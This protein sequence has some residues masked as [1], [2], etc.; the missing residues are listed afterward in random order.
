MKVLIE[1][2]GKTIELEIGDTLYEALSRLNIPIQSLCSGR[3][4]CGRCKVKIVKGTLFLN[5]IT[6]TEFQQLTEKEVEDGF[7]LA[8]QAKISMVPGA[9]VV[10]VPERSLYEEQVLQVEGLEIQVKPAPL[11]AKYFVKLTKPTLKDP[12]SDEDRLLAKLKQQHDLK[13]LTINSDL[14]TLQALPKT[15]RN[16]DWKSTVVMWRE[17]I[18]GIEGG[19]TRSRCFGLAVDL[20]TTKVVGYL[21]NLNTGKVLSQCAQM[22]EQIRCGED[23]ISRIAYILQKREEGLNDLQKRAINT[24]NMITQKCC[25]E[26]SVLP[27]E[28]YEFTIVGNTCMQLLCL[29]IPPNYLASLPYTP[30][31]GRGFDI[32]AQEVGLKGHINANL[33]ILPVIG[34]FVG[35]DN[36][37]VI[38][39]TNMLNSDNVIMCID[40]GTNTEIDLGNKKK[41]MAVSCASGPAFEGMHIRLGMRAAPGAISKISID[42]ENPEHV[43]YETISGEAP[44]GICGSA[45]VDILAELLKAGVIDKQGGYNKSLIESI[46][47][48]RIGESGIEYVVAWQNDTALNTDIIFTQ[49]DIREIQKAKA[50]IHAGAS[51][52]MDQMGYEETDIETLY[53]AGA[54]GCYI[55]PENARLIGMYPEIPIERIEFVG[56]A[57]GTGARLSLISKTK[58]EFCEEIRKKV[59]YFELA[60]HPKFNEEFVASTLLPHQDIGR[61]PESIKFLEKYQKRHSSF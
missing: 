6:P 38:L 2:D 30:V 53:I 54:F 34:G 12:R 9:I 16:N 26:A 60:T 7:R 50:A 40:I 10:I 47:R 59:K 58:N 15:L 52:L 35:G 1:P 3:G 46:Q 57:A 29:G 51:L 32:Q 42:P 36:V 8:C 14:R 22:N 43:K 49:G 4:K 48:L 31:V 19:D 5:Y 44:I 13:P 61:Y 18:I 25:E 45:M 56:N 23:V 33:H 41:V 21:M 17:K 39:A 28:I 27:E 11:I 24:I 37:A 55:N 20:G